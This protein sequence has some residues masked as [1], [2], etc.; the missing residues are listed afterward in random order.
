MNLVCQ[1]ATS[2]SII[3]NGGHWGTCDEHF[4]KD[5]TNNFKISNCNKLSSTYLLCICGPFFFA[6]CLLIHNNKL[7]H[8]KAND[9]INFRACTTG[10]VRKFPSIYVL[11]RCRHQVVSH[12]SME[13]ILKIFKIPILTREFFWKLLFFFSVV[14]YIVRRNSVLVTSPMRVKGLTPMSDRDRISPYNI[15]KMGRPL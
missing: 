10:N 8:R 4:V 15:N 12:A 6:L 9:R 14:S 1:K 5:P 3:S 11:P 2:S 7:K 13:T